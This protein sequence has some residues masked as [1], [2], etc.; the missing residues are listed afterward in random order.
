MLNKISAFF[1]D[2]KNLNSHLTNYNFDNSYFLHKGK[3]IW[4]ERDY[5]AFASEAYMKNVI[6]HRAIEMISQGAASVPFKLFKKGNNYTKEIIR[7]PLLS[8]LKKPT[9]LSNGKAMMQSLYSYL[10]IHGNAY[11]LAVRLIGRPPSELIPLRPDRVHPVA[12]DHYMPSAYRYMI[13]QKSYDY[14][15]NP[16]TGHADVLHWRNFHPLSDWFGLSPIEAAAYSIDQHNQAGAWNQSLLQNGAR[17]SGA[18]VLR[19]NAGVPV[20]LSDEQ[21]N[22][23]RQEIDQ[24]MAGSA[25][26]GRPI[27]LEGGLE[28]MEMS[29]S[30][31]DMDFIEAKHSAARDIALA[32]GMPPQ[33]LGIP[34]DNTYSNLVEARIAL[35][36]QTIIPLLDNTVE[37]LSNWLCHFY[38]D[39]LELAYDL[40]NIPALASKREAVWARIDKASFMTV[41]EKRA[42]VGLTP[43]LVEV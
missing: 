28:W 23:L 41:D 31:K 18:L 1:S 42:A 11:L 22:R 36:E 12:G 3:P 37:L 10:L 24:T 2:K 15:I 8:L 29:M 34:G 30:P 25:N 14:P 33:L 16:M 19:N 39:D 9:P 6:A 13:G 17:P 43:N 32:F 7:H 5:R 20:K 21:F 40:E 4:M 26:A 35:W 38:A 27:I